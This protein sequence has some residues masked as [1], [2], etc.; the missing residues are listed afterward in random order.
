MIFSGRGEFLLRKNIKLQ[1][2]NDMREI[3]LTLSR[4][5]SIDQKKKKKKK[6]NCSSK[7]SLELLELLFRLKLSQLC[8][9][10][11][12][13]LFSLSSLS[14]VPIVSALFPFCSIIIVILIA[15]AYLRSSRQLYGGLPRPCALSLRGILVVERRR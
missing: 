5:E 9:G 15:R 7:L 3:H 11:S 14:P 1:S 10:S 8:H 2:S 6:K 13:F 12:S 4:F